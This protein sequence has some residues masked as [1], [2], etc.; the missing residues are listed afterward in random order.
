MK[1]RKTMP[2][3][4]SRTEYQFN[5]GQQLFEYMI[6]FFCASTVFPIFVLHL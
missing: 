1:D 2:F 6:D 4:I 5:Q 3:S